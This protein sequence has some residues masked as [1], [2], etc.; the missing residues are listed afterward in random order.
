[1]PKPKL[2]QQNTNINQSQDDNIELDDLT[3]HTEYVT[4]YEVVED[5]ESKP[6]APSY[7][8]IENTHDTV[9]ELDSL[10]ELQAP[11]N[12]TQSILLSLRKQARGETSPKPKNSYL[13]IGYQRE[14]SQS[15]LEKESNHIENLP[16]Y[17]AQEQSWGEWAAQG[18]TNTA[19]YAWNNPLKAGLNVMGYAGGAALAGFSS[20]PT[21]GN[22]LTSLLGK[23]SIAQYFKAFPSL[24]YLQQGLSIVNAISSWVVNTFLNIY[25]LSNAWN[26][27]KSGKDWFINL[28]ASP[29]ALCAAIAMAAITYF[30]GLGLPL[31]YLT[32]GI[33]AAVTFVVSLASRYIGVRDIF[34]TIKNWFSEDARRQADFGDA[35]NH[36]NEKYHDKVENMIHEILIEMLEECS[37]VLLQPYEDAPNENNLE[38][39]GSTNSVYVQHGDKVYFINKVSKE[40]S[41]LDHLSNETINK[42]FSK[43]N[44]GKLSL[45]D[46][47]IILKATKHDRFNKP[48]TS[49]EFEYLAANLA[50]KLSNFVQENEIP[51]LLVDPSTAELVAKY[52]G[53][54]FDLLTAFTVAVPTSLIYTVRGKQGAHLLTEMIAQVAGSDLSSLSLSAKRVIEAV[55]YAVGVGA[56]FATSM[57]Y[58]RSQY[59]LRG[60]FND[61]IDYIY[62]NPSQGLIAAPVL[63]ADGFSGTGPYKIGKDVIEN[64]DE[65]LR[66]TMGPSGSPFNQA[67]V[68]LHGE[69]GTAVNT[70]GLLGQIFFSSNKTAVQVEKSDIAKK[71][72]DTNSNL[73]SSAAFKDNSST[74]FTRVNAAKQRSA[75]NGIVFYPVDDEASNI[76]SLI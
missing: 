26:K 71:A 17:Q 49:S 15:L 29:F 62:E 1:M 59:R 13:D 56:G 69:A 28:A 6:Q 52:S 23:M 8:V 9:I 54:A 50:L 73:F 38:S 45:D 34:K 4:E 51:D 42:T 19:K 22:A 37:F 30:S 60:V 10:Q 76:Y 36:I 5:I 68:L 75:D 58:F 47:E 67:A 14:Q 40:C 65:I 48:L 64:N 2:S 3:N 39:F 24:S 46:Q 33:P 25:F 12:S 21:A 63:I 43:L 31:A 44:P 55:E 11:H 57:L 32:A 18:I 7:E 61:L 66:A 74:L 16:N 20:L 35:L 41:V 72:L 53:I 70:V 27:I